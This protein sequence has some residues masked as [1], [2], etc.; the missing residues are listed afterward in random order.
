[1]LPVGPQPGQAFADAITGAL[2]AAGGEPTHTITAVHVED[3]DIPPPDH[4][5][6]VATAPLQL[7][8]VTP[9]MTQATIVGTLGLFAMAGAGNRALGAADTVTTVFFAVVGVGFGA[10]LVYVAAALAM[11]RTGLA[12]KDGVLTKRTGP[13]P[14]P[15]GTQQ[16]RLEDVVDVVLWRED[17]RHDRRSYRFSTTYNVVVATSA[18]DDVV[19]D[20]LK[21]EREAAFFAQRLSRAL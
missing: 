3:T 13:L 16:A 14:M 21:D 19:I 8:W 20:G 18:G 5:E 12:V 6:V 7:G 15:R 17:R 1:V 2:M 10:F 9:G 11:N 4:V